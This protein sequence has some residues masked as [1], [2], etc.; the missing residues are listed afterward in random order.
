MV[1]ITFS[2]IARN[3]HFTHVADVKHA[4]RLTHSLV[5][6]NDTT[7][8]NRHV[9]TS[10]RRH[11]CSQGYVFVIET[12]SFVF[13]LYCIVLYSLLIKSFSKYSCAIC[14]ISPTCSAVSISSPSQSVWRIS[15]F[16]SSSDNATWSFS[17]VMR[18]RTL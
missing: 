15:V 17:S 12:G 2:I 16:T 6:V 9:E 7:I 11:Q 5:L 14:S 4:T 13:H 18:C 1:H 8:L 10:E 3:E